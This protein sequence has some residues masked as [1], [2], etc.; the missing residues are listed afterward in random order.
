MMIASVKFPR[1][2]LMSYICEMNT[3]PAEPGDWFYNGH[4]SHVPAKSDDR[5]TDDGQRKAAG[6]R[7]R[8]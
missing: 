3:G 8:R 2:V 5:S 7:N 1:A 4:E 6:G